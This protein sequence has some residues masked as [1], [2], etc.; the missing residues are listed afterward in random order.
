MCAAVCALERS[1]VS[2]ASR[3]ADAPSD[4][5]LRFLGAPGSVPSSTSGRESE[6]SALTCRTLHRLEEMRRSWREREREISDSDQSRSSSVSLSLSLSVCLSVCLWCVFLHCVC[7]SLSVCRVFS[8][9]I[10]ELIGVFQRREGA[11]GLVVM[12]KSSLIEQSLK[13][14]ESFPFGSLQKERPDQKEKS[15]QIT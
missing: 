12:V 14:F 9:G 8:A 10:P 7:R 2:C 4:E 11:S 5:F 1:G 6:A 15:D 13:R 3:D